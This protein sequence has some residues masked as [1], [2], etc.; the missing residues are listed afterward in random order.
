V[1]APFS[2]DN[3]L[4]FGAYEAVPGYTEVGWL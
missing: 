2:A 1:G 4:A 3:A